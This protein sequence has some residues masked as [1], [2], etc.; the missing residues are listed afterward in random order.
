[1]FAH[2]FCPP[3]DEGAVKCAAFDWGRDF[4]RFSPSV[5]CLRQKPP[6]SSEGGITGRRDANNYAQNA[7]CR[8]VDTPT[9]PRFVILNEVKNLKQHKVKQ[10]GMRFFG[11]R[12]R[13]KMG[14]AN[15]VRPLTKPN[16]YTQCVRAVGVCLYSES[17]P[18]RPFTTHNVQKNGLSR[19]GV[20]VSLTEL[21]Y[22][23]NSNRT[24]VLFCLRKRG[25][26]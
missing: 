13:M 24:F 14:Q 3:S 26:Q 5:F 1:M 23:A 20:I 12:L 25:A 16:G 6:P 21:C 22:Y 2:R 11:C 17:L 10:Y 4:F 18:R 7:F 19:K 8:S 15:T 9:N